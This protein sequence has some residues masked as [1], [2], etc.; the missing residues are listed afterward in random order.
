MDRPYPV[1]ALPLFADPSVRTRRTIYPLQLLPA[2]DCSNSDANSTTEFW[3]V[4][5]AVAMEE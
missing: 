5:V 2:A 1:V 3:N 4:F